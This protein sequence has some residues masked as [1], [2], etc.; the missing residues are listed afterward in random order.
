[1]MPNRKQIQLELKSKNYN[2]HENTAYKF[3]RY[4][5]IVDV[6]DVFTYMHNGNI[7]RAFHNKDI[8]NFLKEYFTEY[9]I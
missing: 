3:M 6:Q 5:Y 1:M 7:K 8:N 9:A 4:N 2:Y